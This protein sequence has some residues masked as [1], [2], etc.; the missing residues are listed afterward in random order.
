MFKTYHILRRREYYDY[1]LQTNCLTDGII[2]VDGKTFTFT[3]EPYNNL[4]TNWP[5]GQGRT[6]GGK[7][8]DDP[9]G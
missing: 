6:L 5:D 7:H 1:Y 8:S 4:Y 2:V 9:A 3:T